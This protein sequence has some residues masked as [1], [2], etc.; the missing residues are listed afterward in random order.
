MEFSYEL[1]IPHE[2][3]AILIGKDGAVKK[4]I[5]SDTKTKISIDS[6]EG[7]IFISGKDAIGLYSAREVILAIGRGFN[8]DIARLLLKQD[9][10]FEYISLQD[11]TGKSKNVL[12]RLKG[13]VIGKDGKARQLIEELSEAYISVYGKTICIIGT[14]ESA[15]IAKKAVESL[16]RGSTHATV[17]KWLERK[18]REMKRKR[19]IEMM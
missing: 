9:Y 1:K 18:R 4:N 3:V 5:E 10:S 2:R 15:S 14:P 16:L 13:R 12:L 6:D 11:F 17:Y 7:D 8:P 19:A